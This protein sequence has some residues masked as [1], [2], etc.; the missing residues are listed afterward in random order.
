MTN[1][2]KKY[3]KYKTKYL[4]LVKMRGGAGGIDYDS[5]PTHL[6]AYDFAND[7][8]WEDVEKYYGQYQTSGTQYGTVMYKTKIS[9]DQFNTITGKQTSQNQTMESQLP[10]IKSDPNIVLT[11]KQYMQLPVDVQSLFMAIT[12]PAKHYRDEVIT[13]YYKKDKVGPLYAKLNQAK[14]VMKPFMDQVNQLQ[15]NGS[16]QARKQADVIMSSGVYAQAQNQIQSIQNQIYNALDT[17]TTI[18]F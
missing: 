15:Q 14:Q 3:I 1:Y 4:N 12:V 7:D 16:M 11:S 6:S 2:E 10:K 5:L 18:N 17:K 8:R 13:E 9:Q